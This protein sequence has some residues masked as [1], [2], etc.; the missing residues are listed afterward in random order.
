VRKSEKFSW[1]EYCPDE[2]CEVIRTRR[3]ISRAE[4]SGFA[5][6]YFFYVSD[7]SYLEAWKSN[8]SVKEAADIFLNSHEQ[9][10]CSPK[11]GREYSICMLRDIA[12]KHQIEILFVR[13]DERRVTVRRLERDAAIR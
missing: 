12:D 9:V 2:T 4:I 11:S 8:A 3:P 5:L 10:R 13:H 1:A 6:S 7:Y